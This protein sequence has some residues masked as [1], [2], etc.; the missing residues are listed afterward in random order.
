MKAEE[1]AA[2]QVFRREIKTPILFLAKKKPHILKTK[3]RKNKTPK[4][5]F[6]F[7]ILILALCPILEDAT[8]KIFTVAGFVRLS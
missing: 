5:L 4:D 7:L 1:A 3:K 2:G 8:R 6:L